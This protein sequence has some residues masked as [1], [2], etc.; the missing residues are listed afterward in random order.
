[1]IHIVPGFISLIDHGSMITLY[2]FSTLYWFV[3]VHF[4]FLIPMSTRGIAFVESSHSNAELRLTGQKPCQ[5]DDILSCMQMQ[6]RAAVNSIIIQIRISSPKFH[7]IYFA[8]VLWNWCS[9]ICSAASLTNIAYLKGISFN[10]ENFVYCSSSFSED[11]LAIVRQEWCAYIYALLNAQ[12]T[13]S[14]T[15]SLTGLVSWWSRMV[16]SSDQTKTIA[17]RKKIW[18]LWFDLIEKVDNCSGSLQL[19]NTGRFWKSSS[20]VPLKELQG[21]IALRACSQQS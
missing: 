16:V 15:K 3:S 17:T 1:M 5:S 13:T 6:F 10:H 19:F 8:P 11:G 12:L 20:R 7:R 9:M 2:L 14:T 21:S 4:I 18:I